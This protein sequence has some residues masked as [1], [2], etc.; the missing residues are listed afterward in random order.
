[1]RVPLSWLREAVDVPAGETAREVA[2]RLTRA[3][4]VVEGV[5]TAGGVVS[6]PVVTGRVLEFADEP[7]K[8]GKTIR[9][10]QV[11]VDEGEP[12]GIVCGAA[13]FAPGDV[14]V[15]A[16]P[17]SVLPGDFA[18]SARK[19]YGHVSD[20]MI[21]SS[22]ELGVGDEHDGILVLPE[23]T[24]VG[25]PAPDLLGLADE[26]L[27]V[28]VTPD[29]GYALS[30]RGLARELATAYDVPFRD[31]AALV[32][33]PGPGENW[34]VRVDDPSGC[35]RFVTRVVTGLDATAPS[36][37]WLSS[38]LRAAGMRPIG[39][40]VDVTNY[41]MLE[42]GQPIHGYDRDRLTGE[43]VV[44][45][46]RAGERLRTLDGAERALDPEDLLITDGSG[47]IGI[48]GVM[49]GGSTEM[50]A[51]TTSV[52]VEAAHF[53]PVSIARSARRHKLPSEASRR[54]ERDVDPK[55]APVAAQR[56]V[57]L[58][59]ELGGA[60]AEPGAT[61]VGTPREPRTVPLPASRVTRTAGR[62]VPVDVV[63]RRLEQVGCSVVTGAAGG[64]DVLLVTPPSWRPDLRD[65]ADLDEEVL[66]LEGYESIP[67]RV[68]Q[69]PAGRGLTA[70]QRARR[71]VTRALAAAG[72]VETP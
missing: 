33:Q 54:F 40:A 11:A 21:C 34:P 25:Q 13:N 30:V 50:S 71:E 61:E 65:P 2:R 6:G 53:D 18:I 46:A 43:V 41:V 28:A 62:E 29:R 39:L 66:R 36:P 3:G 23:G 12:R 32:P 67:S 60:T 26:V 55:L 27:D 69:A 35:T 48:A 10:C 9:W 63:R 52:V 7:Q 70:A 24:P 44:R 1:M 37:L 64:G 45:R 20:G 31:P 16:L 68:P 5:E 49:G 15:V 56:A 72:L 59:V 22:R 19:T 14:V 17:G 51:T 38:R 8:N 47:P 58:L 42:L 4:F 57:D